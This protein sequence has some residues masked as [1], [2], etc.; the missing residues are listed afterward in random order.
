MAHD[1]E[2]ID[3]CASE[4]FPLI[5]R[6]RTRPAA[7]IDARGRKSCQGGADVIAESAA[8]TVAQR[9]APRREAGRLLGREQPLHE[10]LAA[11]GSV[12]ATTAGAATTTGAAGAATAEAATAKPA[13]T[14][15]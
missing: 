9:L 11:I 12:T 3:I 6:K 15:P 5:E 8:Q 4:E 1:Y 2:G 7:G 13:R 10:P 14:P